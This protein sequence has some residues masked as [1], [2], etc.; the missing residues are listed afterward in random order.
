MD[1]IKREPLTGLMYTVEHKEGTELHARY[2]FGFR[3]EGRT[4]VVMFMFAPHSTAALLSQRP[5]AFVMHIAPPNWGARLVSASTCASEPEYMLE[6]APKLP[7][8]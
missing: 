1:T 6:K 8:T 4:V 7:H 5:C 3:V 2:P